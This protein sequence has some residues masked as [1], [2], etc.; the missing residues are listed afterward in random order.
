LKDSLEQ[1][2]TQDLKAIEVL[3]DLK[4]EWVKQ[5]PKVKQALKVKQVPKDNGERQVIKVLRVTLGLLDH[6]D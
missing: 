6:S 1:K 4:A 2:A 5:A 3:K